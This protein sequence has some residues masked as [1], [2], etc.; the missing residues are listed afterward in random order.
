MTAFEVR[1]STHTFLP[2]P[3]PSVV[4]TPIVSA[5]DHFVEPR[6]VFTA[7]MAS[8][9]GEAIPRIVEIDGGEYWDF[10]GQVEPM[11][12]AGTSVVGRPGEEWCREPTRFDE[13]R[14]GAYDPRQR[15][16]DMDQAGIAASLCF[17]SVFFGFAG[18]RFWQKTRD[19]E[20]G[21]AAM[22]AYNDWIL[23]EWVATDPSRFI[24]QQ[25]TWLPDPQLAAAEIRRNATRGFRALSFSENPE[26]LGLPSIYTDHWDP[27]LRACEE[28]ET[29]IDLHVGS[30]SRTTVPSSDSPS[31]VELAL[32][33]LNAVVACVDWLYSMIPVRFPNLKIV[34]SESG[35][36]WVPMVLERVRRNERLRDTTT[37]WRGLEETPVEVFRRAFWF[38]SIDDPSGIDNRHLIGLDRIMVEVDYPHP[39]TSW[40]DTQALVDA[41][42]GALPDDERDAIAWANAC[43]VYRHP[44]DA[45]DAMRS[46][47]RSGAAPN[48]RQR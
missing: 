14:A 41:E 34:F 36:S 7:H 15:L 8:R 37:T 48:G 30:S 2:E 6:H 16:A 40:P 35:I 43:A 24:A 44:T 1:R 23:E 11:L 29:V 20:Y 45:V 5:D 22:R 46:A 13:T 12:M 19:A 31:E 25:V 10:N 9:W 42:I 28:T 4:R 18:Q 27:L 26:L 38:T 3:A 32:F 39:D 33:P 47:A 21:L 17:P